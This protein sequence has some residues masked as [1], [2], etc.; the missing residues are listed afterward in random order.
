MSERNMTAAAVTRLIEQRNDIDNAIR[1]YGVVYDSLGNCTEW[2]DDAAESVSRG[3][4]VLRAGVY[5]GVSDAYYFASDPEAHFA[6]AQ[7]ALDR[8]QTCLAPAQPSEDEEEP[9]AEP[10][11]EPAAV[12]AAFPWRVVAGLGLLGLAAYGFWRMR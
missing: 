8:L 10:A 9:D 11:A 5:D 3:D 6:A 1:A 4:A 2:V 7:T 12:A